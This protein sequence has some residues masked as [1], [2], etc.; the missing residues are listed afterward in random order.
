MILR[1]L[2]T[3]PDTRP[4]AISTRVALQT[5]TRACY[6]QRDRPTP[7]TGGPRARLILPRSDKSGAPICQRGA[8]D[9]VVAA[10]AQ[11]SVQIMLDVLHGPCPKPDA[12]QRHQ[13]VIE[14]SSTGHLR[15]HQ[16]LIK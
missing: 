2:L 5:G 4:L 10:G 1:A 6:H 13:Q 12:A 11:M 8:E 3:S 15:S 14:K 7:H 16:Q 9:N